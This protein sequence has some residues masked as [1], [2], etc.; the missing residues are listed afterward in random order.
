MYELVFLNMNV[1]N[2]HGEKVKITY[3]A[4]TDWSLQLKQATV[5]S[6]V[7]E[8]FP[9]RIARDAHDGGFVIKSRYST[10]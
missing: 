10:P 9:A 6:P 3:A 4:F 5:H 8:M 7:H 2:V 1:I